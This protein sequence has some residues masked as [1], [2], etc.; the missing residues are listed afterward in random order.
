MRKSHFCAALD[1]SAAAARKAEEDRQRDAARKREAAKIDSFL[2]IATFREW[3]AGY[4]LSQRLFECSRAKTEYDQGRRDA[5]V[6]LIEALASAS[7]D[8][9]EI[10]LRELAGA[11]YAEL[12]E[13]VREK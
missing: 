12:T 8:W 1:P 2:S 10:F 9:G 4:V 13:G 11:R 7:P 6:A 3:I 5:I